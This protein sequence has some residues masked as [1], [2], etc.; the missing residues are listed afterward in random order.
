[1]TGGLMQL[2]AYGAQ[3]VHLTMPY[4]YYN[5]IFELNIVCTNYFT[6]IVIR[7]EDDSI[8]IEYT[9]KVNNII[10]I[11]RKRY[12]KISSETMRDIIVLYIAYVIDDSYMGYNKTLFYLI[13]IKDID[14]MNYINKNNWLVENNKYM[15]SL[16]YY[17]SNYYYKYLDNNIKRQQYNYGYSEDEYETDE[18][19]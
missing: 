12:R 15:L 5:Q 16:G 18:E 7:N 14:I 6:D 4:L 10:N 2:I 9:E 11:I 8:N 17:P 13:K 19:Y 3:D 1:M